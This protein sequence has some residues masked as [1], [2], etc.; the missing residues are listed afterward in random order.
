MLK[1]GFRFRL[2][3]FH[4][5]NPLFHTRNARRI[6]RVRWLRIILK[7]CLYAPGVLWAEGVVEI[8]T[9]AS[10]RKT[11]DGRSAPLAP[12][13]SGACWG[14]GDGWHWQRRIYR[15]GK[16]TDRARGC[17]P[18]S[19]VINSVV[20]VVAGVCVARCQS[21]VIK[22]KQIPSKIHALL[23]TIFHRADFSQNMGWKLRESIIY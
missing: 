6:F 19:L 7:L 18:C 23:L 20:I 13:R 2:N 3:A 4:R 22:N 11:M 16:G 1:I 14:V 10:R 12:R 9:C 8:F 21:V 17:L 5:I 15:P